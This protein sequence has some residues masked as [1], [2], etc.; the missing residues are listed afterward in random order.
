MTGQVLWTI[1]FPQI[2]WANRTD[3]FC[4][5][6]SDQATDKSLS[7]LELS[8]L[9]AQ[10]LFYQGS[11]DHKRGVGGREARAELS[12]P[13]WQ[14][15][16]SKTEIFSSMETYPEE[17]CLDFSTVLSFLLICTRMKDI[18]AWNTCI[19]N[20]LP[21]TYHP[22]ENIRNAVLRLQCEGWLKLNRKWPHWG[23]YNGRIYNHNVSLT[24]SARKRSFERIFWASLI[25]SLTVLFFTCDLMDLVCW[26]MV[27]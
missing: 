22:N 17:D 15:M 18:F 4:V 16:I 27:S 12:I 7:W 1:Y 20:A 13:P 3:S 5:V 23:M 11:V 19:G 24:S 9:Q 8:S 2:H 14:T 26:P 25:L 6:C 21:I 10:N